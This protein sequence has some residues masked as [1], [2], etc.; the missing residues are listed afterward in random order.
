MI[1]G[2][3]CCPSLLDS[4]FCGRVGQNW[5]SVFECRF[6]STYGGEKLV[7]SIYGAGKTGYPHVED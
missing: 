4:F 2:S 7:F 5:L 3:E 6:S 1:F